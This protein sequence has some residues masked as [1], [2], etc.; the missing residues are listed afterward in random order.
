MKRDAAFYFANLCADVARCLLAYKNNDTERYLA[1]RARARKTLSFL[2]DT[3]RHEA[4]EEG[5]LLYNAL[6]YV[7]SDGSIESLHKNLNTLAGSIPH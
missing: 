2:R 4:Y 6:V 7:K 1:S 3:G 5:L